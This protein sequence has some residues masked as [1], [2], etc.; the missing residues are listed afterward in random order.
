MPGTI[1]MQQTDRQKAFSGFG[2]CINHV[3]LAVGFSPAFVATQT[4]SELN[5]AVKPTRSTCNVDEET[6]SQALKQS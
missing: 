4:T 6:V 1:L 2:K 5:T 3:V